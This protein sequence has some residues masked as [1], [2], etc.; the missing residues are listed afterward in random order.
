VK[1]SY[2]ASQYDV[3]KSKKFPLRQQRVFMLLSVSHEA[4][5][6]KAVTFYDEIREENTLTA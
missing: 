2:G 3:D 1:A 5:F 6:L 4:D